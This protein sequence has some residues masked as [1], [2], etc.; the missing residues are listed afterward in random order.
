MQN[1]IMEGV[2]QCLKGHAMPP[3]GLKAVVGFF[4][5]G[6]DPPPHQLGDL[7]NAAM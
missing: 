4:G 5:R 3:E 1:F 7:G 6:N 2:Q